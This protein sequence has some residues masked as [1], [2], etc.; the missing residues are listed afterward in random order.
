AKVQNRRGDIS[1]NFELRIANFELGRSFLLVPFQ[2]DT[3]HDAA[4]L[5]EFFLVMH[6]VRTAKSGDGVILAYT[7]PLLGADLFTHAAI[8]SADHVDIEGL[9]KFLDFGEA[10]RMGDFAWDN[11][12]R[13]RRTNEL[14]KLAGNTTHTP[15]FIADKCRR[16][17]IIVRQIAVPFLLGVLH[18]D[19]RASQQQVFEML[20]RNRQTSDDSRQ[21]QSFAPVQ[22]WSWNGDRHDYFVIN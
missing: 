12:D 7:N 14:A 10:I 13:S 11:L 16:A 15:V 1:F 19:L 8:N 3:V 18:R 5:E 22:L 6:H 2:H 20:K 9:R 4:D 17:P 21:L